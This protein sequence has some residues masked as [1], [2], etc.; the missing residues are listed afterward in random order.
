MELNARMIGDDEDYWRRMAGELIGNW[1]TEKTSVE[2]VCNFADKI[3]LRKD[4]AGFKGDLGFAG[5]KETQKTFSKLRSSVAGLYMWR[6]EH[7]R[8]DGE[9]RRM[10]VAA[11]LALRQAYAFC[12]YSPEAVSYFATLLIR[13]HRYND[14]LLAA[15]TSLRLDPENAG[16]QQLVRSLSKLN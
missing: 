1:I 3:Y 11:D 8:D 14:A 13:L 9:K 6:A 2:E 5:N 16:F 15:K 12:P 10:Q 7:T 4:L